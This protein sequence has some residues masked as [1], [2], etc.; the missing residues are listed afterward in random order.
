MVRPMNIAFHHSRFGPT[1]GSEGYLK[2]LVRRLLALGHQVHVFAMRI[3]GQ[4][5]PAGVRLHVLPVPQFPR[6]RRLL[7]LARLQARAAADPAFD[8]VVGFGRTRGQ[9]LYRDGSGPQADYLAHRLQGRPALARLLAPLD[10]VHQATLAIERARFRDPALRKVQAVSRLTR[11]ALL[12]RHP[13]LAGKV[14]VLWNGIDPER[15]HPLR[16]MAARPA[17][18]AALGLDPGPTTFLFLGN[19]YRRK[20]LDVLLEALPALRGEWRLL[21]A[22]ADRRPEAWRRR[23]A[24]L[25]GRIRWLGPTPRV[26]ELYAAADALL[27]PSRY[28]TFPN[29]PLE[30]MGSGLPIAVSSGIGTPEILEGEAAAM[31]VPGRDDPGA[32]TR[33]AAELLDPALRA[34]RG[35]SAAD[36]IHRNHTWQT[37]MARLLPLYEEAAALR[38]GR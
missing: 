1:G 14:E 27:F 33:A 17:A 26:A 22:G 32:W 24:G 9:D 25:A 28:D 4:E 13:G 36:L 29:V 21:V 37:H 12:R 18:Q 20:G 38:R 7:A 3:Q 10:P 34:A 15:F 6:W 30:A 35:A 16:R 11:D 31:V 19:D 2:E 8:L 5:H 23:G